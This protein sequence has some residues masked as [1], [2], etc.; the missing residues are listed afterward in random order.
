VPELPN[1]SSFACTVDN[2]L[3]THRSLF[4]GAFDSLGGVIVY[5]ANKSFESHWDLPET[6]RD[7]A[8]LTQPLVAASPEQKTTFSNDDQ[9]GGERQESNANQAR[10]NGR[11]KS[12]SSNT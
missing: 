10:Q 8:D 11:D 3:V 12:C 9:S 7:I 6:R 1:Y 5:P 2:D 4:Q